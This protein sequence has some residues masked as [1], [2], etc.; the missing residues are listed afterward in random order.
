MVVVQSPSQKSMSSLAVG[1]PL[2]QPNH[3]FSL[4]GTFRVLALMNIIP[5]FPQKKTQVSLRFIIEIQHIICA[6]MY[7]YE[8][9]QLGF[10]LKTLLIKILAYVRIYP[11]STNAGRDIL[12]GEWV[13]LVVIV[14]V[15][16]L[17][18]LSP[19]KR[20][21]LRIRKPPTLKLLHC[22]TDTCHFARLWHFYNNILM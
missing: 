10:S 8:N 19:H 13:V 1:W 5:K 11:K 6:Y 20:V 4:G 7:G 16:K 18:P 17:L 2:T 9:M 3:P 15:V 21:L 14:V 22:K 12:S